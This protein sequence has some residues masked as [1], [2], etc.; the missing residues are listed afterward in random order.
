MSVL[1]EAITVLVPLQ[2]LSEAFDD[3]LD[4]YKRIAPN[5]SLRAD[6]HLT[7]LSLTTPEDVASDSNSYTGNYLKKVLNMHPPN[8]S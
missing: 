4:A 1:I 5:C 7:A 8:K 3:G 6:E 2:R